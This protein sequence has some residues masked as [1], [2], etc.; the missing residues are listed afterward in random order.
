MF[1]F[2]L[3]FT[4]DTQVLAGHFSE[5]P[6]FGADINTKTVDCSCRNVCP[7]AKDSTVTCQAKYP[8]I[9][10]CSAVLSMMVNPR[11]QNQLTLFTY[12]YAH[13]QRQ[14]AIKMNKCKQNGCFSRQKLTFKTE[15]NKNIYLYMESSRLLRIHKT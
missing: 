8:A 6:S 5:F 13:A 4:R 2:F 7:T 3:L 12:F 15:C 10:F 11:L 9:R 14:G 1:F